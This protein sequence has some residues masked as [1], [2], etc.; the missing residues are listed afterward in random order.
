MPM[1]IPKMLRTG[2]FPT[3][4]FLAR[5]NLIS[6]RESQCGFVATTGGQ[7][8]SDRDFFQNT[9]QL[10]A[11]SSI[12]RSIP[13]H[14]SAYNCPNMVLR[15]LAVKEFAYMH[16]LRSSRICLD[17]TTSDYKVLNEMVE[18]QTLGQPE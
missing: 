8:I 2:L 7:R 9:V 11:F 6:E 4:K 18:I 15:Y 5:A 12:L 17:K 14:K 10:T 3:W 13:K 16:T 1:W